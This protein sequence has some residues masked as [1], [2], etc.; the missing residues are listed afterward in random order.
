MATV[1]EKRANF[2]SK[3]VIN[4]SGGNLSSDSAFNFDER[5]HGFNRIFRTSYQKVML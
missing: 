2:N 1:H 3:L 5:I 4:H